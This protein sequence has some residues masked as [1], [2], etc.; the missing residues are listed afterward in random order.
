MA[1]YQTLTDRR[2]IML[3]PFVDC[4][5]VS[6]SVDSFSFSAC[7]DQQPQ[8][9]PS[10][11][12][13]KGQEQKAKKKEVAEKH[14]AFQRLTWQGWALGED[15]NKKVVHC[16]YG[17]NVTIPDDDHPVSKFMDTL[18]LIGNLENVFQRHPQLCKNESDRNLTVSIAVTNLLYPK[19]GNMAVIANAAYAI[20]ILENCDEVDDFNSVVCNQTVATKIRDL[21]NGGS[22]QERD[23]LKFFSKR[24]SCSCLKKRHSVARRTHPK[25]GKVNAAM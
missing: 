17:L 20:V 12:R 5:V 16:N 23:M 4:A 6:L 8:E 11:K 7:T 15:D 19:D 13:T 1:A 21:H 3:I 9:M 2:D 10:R 24:I 22:G 14:R 25:L 18:Y